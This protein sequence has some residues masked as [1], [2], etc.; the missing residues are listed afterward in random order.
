MYADITTFYGNLDDSSEN[1]VESDING[2]L[3]IINNWFK[4]NKLSLNAEKS[5]LMVFRKKNILTASI[6]TGIQVNETDVCNFLSL[7]N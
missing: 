2:E 6:L 5:K 4:L 7:I 3:E 1:S